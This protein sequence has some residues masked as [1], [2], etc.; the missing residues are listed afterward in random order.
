MYFY[1]TVN[2]AR[3][4]AFEAFG[5]YSKSDKTFGLNRFLFHAD[6]ANLRK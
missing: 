3:T 5:S 4:L 1:Q 6:F 2:E